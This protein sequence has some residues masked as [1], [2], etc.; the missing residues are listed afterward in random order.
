MLAQSAF[1]WF[2]FVVL[3][4]GFYNHF[5]VTL[6]KTAIDFYTEFS[7]S[8]HRFILGQKFIELF[9]NTCFYFLLAYCT[10]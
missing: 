3:I 8:R 6:N 7:L 9:K 10:A 4:L 5:S 1:L 2:V